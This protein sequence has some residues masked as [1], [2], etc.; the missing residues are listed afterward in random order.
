[1]QL[2][3]NLPL[4]PFKAWQCVAVLLHSV[5][6]GLEE[7]HYFRSLSAVSQYVCVCV[8]TNVYIFSHILLIKSCVEATGL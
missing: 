2:V 5:N 6:F 3:K 7:L 1:M 8:C 4:L